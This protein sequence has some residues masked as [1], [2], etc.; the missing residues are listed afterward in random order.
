MVSLSPL[1]AARTRRC[2]AAAS[3][4][5]FR[6]IPIPVSGLIPISRHTNHKPQVQRLLIFAAIGLTTKSQTD[7][8]SIFDHSRKTFVEQRDCGLVSDTSVTGEAWAMPANAGIGMGTMP[9]AGIGM[10]TMPKYVL[11]LALAA[12][13]AM[14]VSARAPS[15]LTASNGGTVYETAEI[16]YGPIRKFVST[17]GPVRALVTVSVGSQLSGQIRQLKADF[18]ME[19][20]AGDELAVIDDKTFV[21]K[22]AQSRA[23]LGAARAMLANQQAALAKAEAIERNAVRLMGRQQTLASKGITATMTLDNAIRDAEVA[24]A[25]VAVVRAQVENAKA[26]IDQREAQVAQA[27]IDL[28]RTRIRSPID[29]TVIART[30]DVGQTVA[31]SLQAPELFKIAQDLRRVFIEAQVSEADVGAVGAGNA[32][33]FR[34]DAYPERRFQGMVKQVRLGGTEINNVVTYAVIIEAA[35]DDRVLLPGMTADA[36]IESAMLDR[37]LRVPNDALRFKPRDVPTADAARSRALQQRFD[38]ELERAKSELA[39]TAEQVAKIDAILKGVPSELTSKAS[40]GSAAASGAPRP[41]LEGETEARI[42]HRLMQAVASVV[43]DAQRSA[44][45]AWKS[46]REAAAGR[47][48]RYDVTVWVLGA[49]GALESRQID[50]GLVDSHFTEVL[51]SVLK[52]GDRVVLR[53]RR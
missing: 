8:E 10:G 45:E 1:V 18:N 22:V 51:G 38:R 40:G 49:S 17:S 7:R 50:L 46:R 12:V 30:V 11:A 24:R 6:D 52:E 47:S 23:D 37:A 33:E 43:T 20:K 13:A 16:T 36:R 28:E 41:A 27:E 21:A 2:G 39:L 48:T 4:K 9:K 31:A 53:A 5:D 3:A 42:M 25:E 19:V 32:V 29:G 44:F 34:V 14:L 26:V 35:N 15:L